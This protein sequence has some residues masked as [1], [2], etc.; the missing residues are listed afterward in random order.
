MALG[1]KAATSNNAC[2]YCDISKDDR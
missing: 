2:I 1:M